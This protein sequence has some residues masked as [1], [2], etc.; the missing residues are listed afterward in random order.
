MDVPYIGDRLLIF[1]SVFAGIQIFFVA[2]RLMT[3]V[4]NPKTWGWD[5]VVILVSLAGQLATAGTTIVIGLKYL[6]AI[7]ILYNI[8][9]NVPKFAILLLYNRVFPPPLRINMF[10]RVMMAFLILQTIAN[11][12]AEFLICGAH[13]ANFDNYVRSTCLSRE[14]FYVWGTFPNI[15]SDVVILVLPMTIIL[16]M[17]ME[18]RMKLGLAVTFLV[19]SLGLTTSILRFAW[20]YQDIAMTD[21][22]WNAV[23]LMIITQAETG[24][25]LICACLPTYRRFVLNCSFRGKTQH[26]HTGGASP[27]TFYDPSRRSTQQK[28]PVY[29]PQRPESVASLHGQQLY[30]N[31]TYPL[32]FVPSKDTSSHHHHNHRP[33]Y[34]SSSLTFRRSSSRLNESPSDTAEQHLAHPQRQSLE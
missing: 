3:R 11:T 28:Q 26:T 6:F 14:A 21:Y 17:H 30:L 24:T 31:D 13:F 23:N 12:L 20:F 8:F 18:T 7:Q 27:P 16:R 25:Y 22:S 1:T 15:I 29:V 19:G 32:T 10:V 5:D 33:S 4:Q 34:A 9:M 2:L